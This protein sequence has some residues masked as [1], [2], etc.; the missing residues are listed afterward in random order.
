MKKMIP[1]SLLKLTNELGS[2]KNIDNKI[3]AEIVS[4]S[5]LTASDFS[6]YQSFDH[7]YAESYGRKLIMDNGKFKILL[8]SWRPG[9]FTAIH[10]HGYTEWGCVCFFGEAT[11]RL[12]TLEKGEL[13]LKQSDTFGEGEV[14]SV[15]GDLTHLMGNAGKQN[16]TT[17]HIYGS[18]TKT[19]NISENAKVY[20]PEF[21]K[22]FTTM[23]SAYLL[24]NQNLILSETGF[25]NISARTLNDYLSLVKPFY[26][27]NGIRNIV[28]LINEVLENPDL[29]YR[30]RL[31]RENQSKAFLFN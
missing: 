20:V 5:R 13:R 1:H 25:D 23:G 9:D 16:F 6:Q 27:R 24:M 17:L 22:I 30:N 29:Y 2:T 14:A 8:M 11:H 12:Y 15:C 19:S 4:G 18:N 31:Q 3:V 26:I 21:R 7:S 28:N 10:N